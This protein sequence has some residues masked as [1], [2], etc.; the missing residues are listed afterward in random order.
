MVR[1]VGTSLTCPLTDGVG[2]AANARATWCPSSSSVH[3]GPALVISDTVNSTDDSVKASPRGRRA[4][5]RGR[6]LEPQAVYALDDAPVT[7]SPDPPAA[8]APAGSSG[9]GA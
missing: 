7:R 4:P 1:S 2:L 6:S 9:R 8:G 3:R 5:R